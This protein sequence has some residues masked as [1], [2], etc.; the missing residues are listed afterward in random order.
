MSNS[1]TE[2]ENELKRVETVLIEKASL[3]YDSYMSDIKIFYPFNSIRQKYLASRI[4][5]G[6][7]V[8]WIRKAYRDAHSSNPLPIDF[9]ILVIWYI[10]SCI[11][12]LELA[13]KHIHGHF[14]RNF[15]D[16]LDNKHNLMLIDETISDGESISKIAN[17]LGELIKNIETRLVCCSADIRIITPEILPYINRKVSISDLAKNSEKGLGNI[18]DM[19]R[20]NDQIFHDKLDNIE[21]EGDDARRQMIL[22]NLRLVVSIAKRYMHSGLQLPDL[23]QEGTLGLMKAVDSFQYRLGFKFSTY[24]TWWIR[25]AITRA[26]SDQA[27][28]I[29]LPVH[30]V[31]A[32]NRYVK[33]R[34]SCCKLQED[35]RVIKRL[36]NGWK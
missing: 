31:E 9:I 4:E 34:N 5:L 24:A 1:L 30:M 27:R 18:L 36:P 28:T 29:R 33:I 11:P 23:I 6:D 16:F 32:I 25:Q 3:V 13:Q 2:S 35:N 15:Y 19:E 21:I 20:I 14:D 12:I 22:S 10:S 26:I 8:K 17:Y 7:R